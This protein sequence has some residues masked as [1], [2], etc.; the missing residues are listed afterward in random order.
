MTTPESYIPTDS[1]LLPLADR[2]SRLLEGAAP[3]DGIHAG[4]QLALRL[5]R[6]LNRLRQPQP[7]RKPLQIVLLGGTGVGK[8]TLFN[9]LI[10]R[11]D[12]SPAS[13]AER[14]FTKQP[15]IAVRPEDR[16]FVTIPNGLEP[17]WIDIPSTGVALID[18]PD[19]D[20]M[21][22]TNHDVTRAVVEAGDLIIYVTF[23][24]KQADEAVLRELKHWAGQKRWFFVLNKM[25]RYHDR[26]KIKE[27]FDHRLTQLG[28]E[29][30]DKV[31][32]LLSSVETQTLDFP[33][34]QHA[35]MQPRSEE[36]ITLLRH[37]SFLAQLTEAGKD[38][39]V[40]PLDDLARDLRK[41][42]AEL[43]GRVQRAYMDGLRTPEA[44]E[45]VRNVVS[46]STW[47]HT[48]KRAGIFLALP[49]WIRC[50]FNILLGG[51]SANRLMR[52]GG[53]AGL[54]GAA[55]SMVM[56]TARGLMPLRQLIDAL[57]P[58]FGQV[59]SEVSADARR[60]LEDR[61]LERLV[62]GLY[63]D[64]QKAETDK[65][66]GDPVQAAFQWIDK[67]MNRWVLSNVD[68]EV[69]KNLSSDVERLGQR[70]SMQTFNSFTGRLR[71]WVGNLI[72][73]G[74]LGWL[75]YRIGEGWWDQRYHPMPFYVMGLAIVLASLIPGY[76]LIST[77]INGRMKRLDPLG[78]IQDIDQSKAS[79][80]L[81]TAA[82]T[83]DAMARQAREL[84]RSATEMRKEFET[85]LPAES[86]GAQQK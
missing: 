3:L 50:R 40:T 29:I 61:R 60:H 68:D 63:P 46:E 23:P 21:L 79:A 16:P 59:L 30:D 24:D 27:S 82:D 34:F 25:D 73:A 37:D 1:L 65:P 20:G 67:T 11:P 12:A 15:F 10:G 39:V 41:K 44:T 76:L 47:R 42:E 43:L 58:K 75:L 35:V 38:E 5:D 66:A 14:C 72:P 19:I 74:M 54:A 18:T 80:S 70:T 31:R 22:S 84:S 71:I 7:T 17:H 9:A 8:S 33:R 62:P 28:F 85:V 83:L 55:A 2:A 77:A 45:T 57:G 56:A 6:A 78:L 64:L 52:M 81:R 36:Q 53:V 51:Y 49:V 32:F 48:G 26:D 69:L 4:R 13:D 86:L